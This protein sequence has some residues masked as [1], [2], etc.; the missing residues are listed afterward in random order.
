VTPYVPG[1]ALLDRLARPSELSE[2]WRARSGDGSLVAVKILRSDR[3]DLV[4]RFRSEG[5]ILRELG[6]RHHLIGCLVVL[7]RPHALVL[8]LADPRSLADR[9]HPDGRDRPAVPLP[10]AEALKAVAEAAEAV[11]WLHRNEVIHRDVKPSNVLPGAGGTIRLI[12]LGIAAR[13]RPPRALPDGWVEEEVGTLGYAAPELVREPSTADPAVDIYAL[14]ATLYEALS[15]RL[16]FELGPG[17]SESELRTRIAGG[18]EPGPLTELGSFPADLA[19]LVTRALAPHP[20]ARP[21]S[22]AEFAAELERCSRRL[23]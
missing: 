20:G 17:D 2:V 15:G 21:R 9:I 3:E 6:G 19:S 11:A 10:V 14:G 12:D 8:E 1:F 4:L 22:A 23:S 13:G 16:P 5:E 18:S 7:D